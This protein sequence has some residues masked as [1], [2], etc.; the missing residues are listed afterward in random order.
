MM[1]F[2]ES[3]L[4]IPPISLSL[5]VTNK[6][7]AACPNCCFGCNPSNNNRLTMDEI[8]GYI[9]QA[10]AQFSSIKLLVITGGECF[11]LEND[12]D[13]TVEYAHKKGLNVRVVTNAY[14][15]ASFKKAY[16]RLKRLKSLGLTELNVSAGDE[17]QMWI[18]FDNIIHALIAAIKLE[19][20]VVV[21]IESSPMSV[22]SEQNIFNDARIRKYNIRN[23][24][25]VHI[26]KGEWVY[27]K[28]RSGSLDASCMQ[29][30]LMKVVNSQNRCTS[31]FRDVIVSSQHYAYACCGLACEYVPFLY[32]GNAQKYRLQDLYNKQFDDFIKIW[33]F[34]EGPA[35]ILDF[36][37]QKLD[38]EP[39]ITSGWH[40]CRICAELFSNPEYLECLKNNYKEVISN[41]IV[42]FSFLRQ[43][44][45]SIYSNILCDEKQQKTKGKEN[46]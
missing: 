26:I 11:T 32:L 5:I 29:Q 2:M 45:L 31:L 40:I 36:V 33:L 28:K 13:K 44:L 35:K 38:K 41:E 21:N 19:M 3:Q 43:K 14:W 20:T 7:T 10:T 37:R 34:T 6:C 24:S 23:N 17:H 18:K 9:D 15:A 22:I 16:T 25:Q 30:H 39:I 12:L 8:V 27:F 46:V 42:K 4:I 1:Q